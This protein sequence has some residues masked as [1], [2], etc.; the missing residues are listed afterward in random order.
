MFGLHRHVWV[1]IE[2]FYAA[3]DN[4]NIKMSGGSQILAQQLM[5]GVTTIRFECSNCRKIKTEELLGI[6]QRCLDQL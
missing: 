4:T 5:Q 2:R 1:E 3:P 6:S